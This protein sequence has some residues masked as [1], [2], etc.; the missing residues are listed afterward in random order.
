LAE[1]PISVRLE[2]VTRIS[3]EAIPDISVEPPRPHVALIPS[4]IEF[5]PDGSGDSLVAL[6]T[7]TIVWLDHEFAIRGT[8]QLP[9]PNELAQVLERRARIRAGDTTVRRGIYNNEG[10][11][12]LAFDPEFESNRSFYVHM[13]RESGKGVGL[14]K[15]KWK[16]NDLNS[17]WR[18]AERL[19]YAPKPESNRVQSQ[20]NGGNP[21]FDPSGNLYLFVGDGGIGGQDLSQNRAQDPESTWGKV[22]RFRPPFTGEPEILAIGLRNPFSH[23]WYG[24]FL[25]I[26]DAGSNKESS[27]EEINRLDLKRNSS[28]EIPNFGWLILHGSS[29]DAPGVESGNFVDPFHGYRKFDAVFMRED[30]DVVGPPP[31]QMAHSAVILGPVYQ[32][33]RYD[34]F[35]DNVL[36]YADYMQGWIR[37][38]RLDDNGDMV[39][40]Q[41]LLHTQKPVGFAIGPDGYIY[42]LSTSLGAIAIDRIELSEPE[43][44]VRVA[45]SSSVSLIKD[46]TQGFPAQLEQTGLFESL[47]GLVPAA[48]VLELRLDF[49][50]WAD[51]GDVRHFLSLPLGSAIDTERSEAWSFPEGTV[52][53]RHVG[54]PQKPGR[55]PVPVET[56]LLLKSRDGWKAATYIWSNGEAELGDGRPIRVPVE[57]WDGESVRS[58]SHAIPGISDCA[59]CH[60]SR[61]DFLIGVEAIRFSDGLPGES[62]LKDLIQAKWV[63]WSPDGD[64]PS[65][66][67]TGEVDRNARAYLHANCGHCHTQGG[68]SGTLDF[69]LEHDSID[70]VVGSRAKY[71]GEFRV[72][73]GEPSQS[74]LYRMMEHDTAV[75]PMPPP[76]MTVDPAGLETVRLW[77]ESLE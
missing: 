42:V 18:D 39:E 2:T 43:A 72:K 47:D 10:V 7:G 54:F 51:G 1:G 8:F 38:A 30:P 68:L 61:S 63:E 76:P 13:N 48:G 14:W 62:S 77:I 28:G 75:I 45:T 56:Q 53:A 29:V 33:D 40:D 16:P 25:F 41:H 15:L 22:L 12:G 11:L 64:W 52:A 71:T 17:I 24:R 32:G 55:P 21:S 70:D 9:S 6:N 67:S 66:E 37:G 69:S 58:I 4:D 31:G 60:R 23:A 34:G 27:W 74:L 73:A 46:R 44:P 19:F 50:A 3:A 65:I 49:D 5:F 59:G 57:L 20:H 26:G 36:I 35:L